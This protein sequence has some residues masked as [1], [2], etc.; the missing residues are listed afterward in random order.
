MFDFLLGC[1]QESETTRIHQVFGYH[2][3]GVLFV[4]VSSSREEHLVAAT[5]R[6]IAVLG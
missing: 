6:D 5:A 2:L 1:V 4:L 3:T